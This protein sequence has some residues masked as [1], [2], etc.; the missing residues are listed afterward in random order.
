MAIASPRRT[1]RVGKAQLLEADPGLR[2]AL[3]RAQMEA[4]GGIFVDVQRLEPGDWTP[5]RRQPP[6]GHLGLLLLDGLMSRELV[7]SRGTGL[8]L[9]TAGDL[10]RPWQEDAASFDEARWRVLEPVT[11][12]ELGPGAATQIALVPA[13]VE[14]MVSRVM[15][16]CRSLAALAAIQSITGLEDRLLALFWHLA[17][18]DGH[19]TDQGVFVPIVLTHRILA[20]LIGARRPSVT[21]ALRKLSDEGLLVRLDGEGWLLSGDPPVPN[22]W[23]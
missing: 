9:L 10:L 2:A 17:E 7:I 18:R 8:E 13:L 5:D 23:T 19:R 16:R 4:V 15:Q 11:I 12:A 1:P 6:P 22:A 20:Q 21:V 14:V 3:S